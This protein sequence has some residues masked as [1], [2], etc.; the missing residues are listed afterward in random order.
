L[1]ATGASMS[2]KRIRCSGCSKRISRS[3]PDLEL[4]GL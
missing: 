4:V 2:P 1:R 3:E